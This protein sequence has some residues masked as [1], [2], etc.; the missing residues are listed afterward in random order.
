MGQSGI[1]AV[2]TPAVA[3]RLAGQHRIELGDDASEMITLVEDLEDVG[4]HQ[5][6]DRI[7]D[8]SLLI[9]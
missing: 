6:R 1:S 8:C 4:V 9:A 3:S 2:S 7:G 5:V